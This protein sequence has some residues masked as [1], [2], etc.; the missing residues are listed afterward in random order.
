MAPRELAVSSA[1]L[2][3]LRWQMAW[4]DVHACGMNARPQLIG[5]GR[6]VSTRCQM[7]T[8]TKVSNWPHGLWASTGRSRLLR[9]DYRGR[10]QRNRH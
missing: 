5:G 6:V 1:G 3:G 9:A 8:E 7:L 2:S 10:I 4:V